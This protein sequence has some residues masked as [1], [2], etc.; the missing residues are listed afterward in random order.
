[1]TDEWIEVDENVLLARISD[2]TDIFPCVWSGQSVGSSAVV[3]LPHNGT[4]KYAL[5]SL[6]NVGGLQE[7]L[8]SLESEYDIGDSISPTG[9][10][11]YERNNASRDCV[12]C[13]ETIEYGEPQVGIDVLM[14]R[15]QYVPSSAVA[16]HVSCTEA[17]NETLDGV[18]DETGLL[19]GR[20]L[21]E[22]N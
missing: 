8:Q 18:W 17:F 9:Y 15:P 12:A 2:D 14:T 16:V 19:L 13:G 5:L 21:T 10:I 11:R 7:V 6:K 4:E 22:E 3:I 20:A 1:M